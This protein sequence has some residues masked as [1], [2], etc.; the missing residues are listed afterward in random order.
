MDA[1]VIGSI[2]SV[3]G[4]ILVVVVIGIRISKLINTTHSKD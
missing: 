3:V 4:A 1:V 2:L